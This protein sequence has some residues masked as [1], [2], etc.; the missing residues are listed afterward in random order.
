MA[1]A[2]QASGL[3]CAVKKRDPANVNAM[4]LSHL[5]PLLVLLTPLPAHADTC[6]EVQH[7]CLENCH[8]D[9][10]LAA[11]RVKLTKCVGRCNRAFGNCT[12]LRQAQIQLRSEVGDQSEGKRRSDPDV[13][14][15]D[16][17]DARDVRVRS[18]DDDFD[19]GGEYRRK[20]RVFTHGISQGLSCT[21]SFC[22][23]PK[24]FGDFSAF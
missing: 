12:D 4:R 20:D 15:Y 8:I 17:S 5:A 14:S 13:R 3:A 22:K 18:A 24:V 23:L 9:F 2:A 19:D 10:G 6:E 11:D 16:D 1:G 21:E 7:G